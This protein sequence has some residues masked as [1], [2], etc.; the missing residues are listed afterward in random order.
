VEISHRFF[1]QGGKGEEEERG[2]RKANTFLSFFLG[3]DVIGRKRRGGKEG[4][5]RG[6]REGE[7]ERPVAA[8][9]Q[10][11]GEGGGKEREIALIPD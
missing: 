2:E 7:R 3:H 9:M 10:E 8:G 5:G 1:F 11:N 4:E 6:K